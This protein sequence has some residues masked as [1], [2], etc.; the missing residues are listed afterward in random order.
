MKGRRLGTKGLNE[1]L[2]SIF[3]L[4]KL[5]VKH[6]R[7]A[8]GKYPQLTISDQNENAILKFDRIEVFA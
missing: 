4:V 6:R 7:L 1:D 3:Q 2:S 5:I 8:L